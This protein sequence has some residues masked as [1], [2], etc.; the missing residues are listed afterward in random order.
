MQFI[1]TVVFEVLSQL[2]N[3]ITDTD[4]SFRI[5]DIITLNI[6]LCQQRIVD[7]ELGVEADST[8]GRQQ[9]AIRTILSSVHMMRHEASEIRNNYAII[10]QKQYFYMSIQFNHKCKVTKKYG[11]EQ[12]VVPKKIKLNNIVVEDI[13]IQMK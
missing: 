5:T 11:T 9:H 6:G 12:V 2:P 13:S 8:C 1:A 4:Q 7:G 3:L 10:A